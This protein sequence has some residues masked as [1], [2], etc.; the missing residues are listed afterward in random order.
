MFALSCHRCQTEASSN[1]ITKAEVAKIAQQAA[2]DAA[3]TSEAQSSVYKIVTFGEGPEG[4]V[5]LY[6][7]TAFAIEPEIMVTSGHILAE[8][9]KTVIIDPELDDNKLGVLIVSTDGTHLPVVHFELAIK[10]DLAFLV[11]PGANAK[12]ISIPNS[13]DLQ[14][15]DRVCLIEAKKSYELGVHCGNVVS[16]KKETVISKMH[17]EPGYSGSPVVNMRGEL[18]GIIRSKTRYEETGDF[19]PIDILF[20]EIM[21]LMK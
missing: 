8:A 11:A 3:A 15:K 10:A 13:L 12:P 6:V 19:V 14:A 1:S 21:T 18:V 7:G 2:A 16:I 5:S 4:P 20:K 17:I 9:R